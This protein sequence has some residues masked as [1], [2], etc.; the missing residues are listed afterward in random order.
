M[1]NHTPAIISATEAQVLWAQWRDKL[2]A[3]CPQHQVVDSFDYNECSAIEDASASVYSAILGMQECLFAQNP[4]TY[5]T[6]RT[7][8]YTLKSKP[9]STT[10]L[11]LSSGAFFRLFQPLTDKILKVAASR[12]WN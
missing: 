12:N 4:S 9:W 3:E 7:E 11:A 6:F 2:K 1:K 8:Y 10:K 5:D